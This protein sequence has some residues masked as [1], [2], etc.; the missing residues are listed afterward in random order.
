MTLEDRRLDTVMEAYQASSQTWLFEAYTVLHSLCLTHEEITADIVW[1]HL[2][3]PP[4]PRDGRM[5]GK[6]IRTAQTAVACESQD[7]RRSL[8]G[9]RPH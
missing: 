8:E 6:V 1:P 2:M 9:I 5:F 4:P 3:F 7:G